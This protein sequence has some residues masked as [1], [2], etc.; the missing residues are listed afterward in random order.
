MDTEA[1][2]PPAPKRGRVWVG[3]AIV[4]LVAAL[5]VAVPVAWASHSFDD[6]PDA[7]PHHADI[8][9][10]KNAGITAGC[11]PPTNNLYCPDTAVRRDQMASFMRRGLGRLTGTSTIGT[12]AIGSGAGNGP[13]V[14]V[15]TVQITVPGVSGT[16]FVFV[17]GEA[18]LFTNSLVSA[19]CAGNP[20]NLFLYLYDGGTQLARS[21]HRITSDDEGSTVSVSRALAVAAGTTKTYTLRAQAQNVSTNLGLVADARLIAAAFPFGGS[22]GSTLTSAGATSPADD[23]DAVTGATR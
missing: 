1:A 8:T 23:H 12:T 5:V 22:G 6:V 20:C 17:T 3:Y 2:Q 13:L 16:Q 21:F 15:Q 9:A 4:G 19:A 7:S 10:I 18:G 14:D 11:N